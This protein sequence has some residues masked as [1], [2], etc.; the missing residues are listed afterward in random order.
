M[1]GESG[2]LSYLLHRF[3]KIVLVIAVIAVI[4]LGYKYIVSSKTTTEEQPVPKEQ[5]APS[6]KPAVRMTSKQE[7]KDKIMK[8]N[9]IYTDHALCRM[10]CRNISKDDINEILRRGKLS[11]KISRFNDKPCPSYAYAWSTPSYEMVIAVFVVCENETKLVTAYPLGT[12]DPPSCAT[13]K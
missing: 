5:P 2:F 4:V 8:S 10:D 9:F 3:G 12:E 7:I 1:A 13:C 11:P 6:S